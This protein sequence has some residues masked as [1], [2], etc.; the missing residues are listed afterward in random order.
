MS[1]EELDKEFEHA[2]DCVNA[3]KDP[4]PAD[5]LLKLYAYYKRANHDSQR[6]SGSKPLISA[7]KTNALFQTRNMTI[8]EA[9]QELKQERPLTK[10]L[11]YG[12]FTCLF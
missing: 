1:S 7:F 10:R 11:F 9:K 4:F 8:D 12:K 2:V 5:T 3:H 6:P